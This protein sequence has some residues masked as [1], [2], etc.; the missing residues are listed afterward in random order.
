MYYKD[1]GVYLKDNVLFD[2]IDLCMYKVNE[3][4]IKI[5]DS[6][7]NNSDTFQIEKLKDYN[8]IK[9]TFFSSNRKGKTYNY[10]DNILNVQIKVSNTCN[11]K[12]RYCYAKHGNYGKK[13]SLMS[14]NIAY[15]I[16]KEIKETFPSVQKV[17]FF[18][19][20][21]LMNIDAIETII[22]TIDNKNIKYSMV[23]NGTIMNDR[24]MDILKEND[25]QAI[26]SIDGP[27]EINDLNRIYKN[28]G[29]TY[30]TIE[31]NI[32]K[33]QDSIG[34][35]S[36]LAAVYTKPSYLKY[37]KKEICE[38]LYNTFH[39]KAIGIGNMFTE[40]EELKINDNIKNNYEMKPED[41]VEYTFEKIMN[42]QFFLINEVYDVLCVF[43]IR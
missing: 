31:L 9:N 12:C 18:G 16:A 26:I 15:K 25:I 3:D 5:F 21:P 7:Y 32:K 24:L 37:S 34:A 10:I 14:K 17:S 4:A 11:L 2:L 22:N 6:L 1:V 36:M 23:T 8:L 30:K 19:G 40:I 33:I 43:L 42:K 20:E 29:G 41:L 28:G 39:V 13:D 38:F 35:V 27:E